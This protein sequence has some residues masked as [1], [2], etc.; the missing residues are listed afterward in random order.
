M[1]GG[2]EPIDFIIDLTNVNELQIVLTGIYNN[3]FSGNYNPDSYAQLA[4]VL[5]YR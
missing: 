1:I 3:I 2:I 4:N 5:L